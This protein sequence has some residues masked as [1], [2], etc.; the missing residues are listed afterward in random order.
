M[1]T[2]L[3]LAFRWEMH[4]VT[5]A[6]QEQEISFLAMEI[7]ET[8]RGFHKV[9]RERVQRIGAHLICHQGIGEHH[10]PSFTLITS[11]SSNNPLNVFLCNCMKSSDGLHDDMKDGDPLLL[12]GLGGYMH[13]LWKQVWIY[14]NPLS[15]K[16]H[17]A[18]ENRASF[19]TLSVM[20]CQK[21]N[22]SFAHYLHGEELDFLVIDCD[23][24]NF[25]LPCFHKISLTHVSCFIIVNVILLCRAICICQPPWDGQRRRWEDNLAM[26]RRSTR[27]WTDCCTFLSFAIQERSLKKN[28]RSPSRPAWRGSW[29][30]VAERART[31]WWVNKNIL[32]A[33]T[34][35]HISYQNI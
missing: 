9:E 1:I 21:Q 19:Q 20:Y 31:V 32:E 7:M 8:I 14:C 27:W 3:K 12:A 18:A 33:A 28:R 22:S 11:K 35:K 26:G 13:L 10:L 23:S 4:W 6:C 34:L 15:E 25:W 17:V 24:G 30:S 2:I 29:V 5:H 16:H